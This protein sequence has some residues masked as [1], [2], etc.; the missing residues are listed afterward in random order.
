MQGEFADTLKDPSRACRTSRG[1]LWDVEA[2]NELEKIRRDFVR[3]MEYYAFYGPFD[4][5]ECPQYFHEE[6]KR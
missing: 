6:G 3:D 1:I 4:P 5:K 2:I